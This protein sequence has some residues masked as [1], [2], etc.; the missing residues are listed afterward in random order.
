MLLKVLVV[1]L[2]LSLGEVVN[3]NFRVR[4]LHHLYGRKR[5]K[6]IS[7]FSGMMIIVL[8]VWLTQ[9]WLNLSNYIECFSTGFIWMVML[10]CLDIYFARCVF[11]FKWKKITED[12]NI[13]KGNLL[14]I[15]L[16]LLFFMPSIVFWVKTS[17]DG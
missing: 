12:F 8:I 11:K 7:F 9:P 16:I 4:I 10:L 1:G 6:F 14:S 15:G 5:A 3:G 13:R 17:T 2:L